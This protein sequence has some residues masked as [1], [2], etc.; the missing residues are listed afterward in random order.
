MSKFNL[1]EQRDV[2]KLIRKNVKFFEKTAFAS[3]D[4]ANRHNADADY[5]DAQIRLAE[6]QGL[7]RFDRDNFPVP[8]HRKPHKRRPNQ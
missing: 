2:L 1:T 3:L 6:I 5:L 4:Y 8:G 7:K